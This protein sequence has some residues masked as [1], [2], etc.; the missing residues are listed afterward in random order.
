VSK[1]LIFV[2]CV[3]LL[4][5]CQ[6]TPVAPSPTPAPAETTPAAPTAIAV[7]TRALISVRRAEIPATPPGPTPTPLKVNIDGRDVAVSQL[8]PTRVD[9]SMLPVT[10]I[11]E[12]HFTGEDPGFDSLTWKLEID[13]LVEHP[14]TLSYADI[15]ARPVVTDVV[16]LICPGV[17]ADN[18][19]WSG[20]PLGP[21]LKEAGIKSGATQLRMVGGDAYTF[22]IDLDQ[23]MADGTF[24]AYRVNGL[25]L[26]SKHGFPL[27]AVVGN[28]TGSSWVKWL[29]KITVLGPDS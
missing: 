2:L 4:V 5:S 26:P 28:D 22:R 14:L 20:T 6:A 13:G 18:A 24:L 12:L 3:A 15:L 8:V 19:E 23:A 11:E 10:K 25:P 16:L 21:V 1:L 29:I 17:F 27:R 7:A 9:K